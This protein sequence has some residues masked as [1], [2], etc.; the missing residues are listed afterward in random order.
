METVPMQVRRSVFAKLQKLATPLI[1]DP[2]AVIERLIEHWETNPPKKGMSSS[3]GNEYQKKFWHSS[4]GEKFPLGI[5]LRANYLGTMYKADVT[6]RGIEFAGKVYKNPSRAAIAAK[7]LAGTVLR[8]ASTNGWAFWEMY[9]SES[10]K[11]V[12]IDALR[13]R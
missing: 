6:E 12:S 8:A 7:K 11:W 10:Q 4:R 2:S 13:T 3:S 5:Q 9:D 1:D